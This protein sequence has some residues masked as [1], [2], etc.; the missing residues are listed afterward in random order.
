[1]CSSSLLFN[2]FILITYDRLLYF[3]F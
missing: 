2:F 1:V 3:N